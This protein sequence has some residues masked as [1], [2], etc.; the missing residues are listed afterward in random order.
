MAAANKDKDISVPP[1]PG[2]WIFK[3]LEI[4]QTRWYLLRTPLSL[5][6]N[7]QNV[8]LMH[9]KAIRLLDA[10]I[11]AVEMPPK[12]QYGRLET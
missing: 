4:S 2:Y 3:K 6:G 12:I 10:D 5:K 8:Y 1:V 9:S 7:P 11:I